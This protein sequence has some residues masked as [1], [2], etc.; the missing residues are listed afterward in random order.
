M[1]QLG[2]K[3]ALVTG[4]TSGI[5]LAA[6]RRFAA[7]GAHV[8]I[9]G[10]RKPELDAAAAEIGS[11]VTAV[12]GDVANL[13]DLDHL[14]G[15]IA[16]RGSGLDVVFANAGGGSV[17]ALGDI[18]P[19]QFNETFGINVRGMVFTI[20]KTLP[21]LNRGASIVLAGSSS[22]TNGTPGFSVYAASKATI[23]SFART[24]AAELASRGIRVNTIIPGPTNTPGLRS[25][26]APEVLQAIASGIPL[27]R[28]GEPDEIA[29]A[30]LFLASPESS[31]MTGSEIFIDGGVEQI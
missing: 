5:G 31:F 27:G 28:L 13:D 2:N 9:T 29:N 1:A 26:L 15:A 8:F 20:Q 19:E 23:R 16:R 4:G 30:V 7:E 14:A 18:T 22:A 11:G 12:Q 24:W 17:A 21:Y 6:A 10:R 3:T 25:G